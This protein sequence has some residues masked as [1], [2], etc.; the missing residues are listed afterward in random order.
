MAQKS[1]F[2][3]FYSDVYLVDIYVCFGERKRLHKALKSVA[4][5]DEV[6]WEKGIEGNSGCFRM[7]G[8]GQAVIWVEELPTT[9]KV[10]SYL[11]HEIFHCATQI[12]SRA[13]LSHGEESE[14]AYAYLI[15]WLTLKIWTKFNKQ[16][17]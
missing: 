9:P 16:L 1:I 14:E 7:Y 3:Q 10:I 17:Q 4:A 5:H 15:G 13:G 2:F 6:E 11:A 12:L 8:G